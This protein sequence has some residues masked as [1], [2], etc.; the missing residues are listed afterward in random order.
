MANYEVGVNNAT[1]ESASLL[2]IAEASDSAFDA[3]TIFARLAIGDDITIR[4]RNNIAK[5]VRFDLAGAGSDLGT[6]WT[7]PVVQAAFVTPTFVDDDQVVLTF[8]YGGTPTPPMVALIYDSFSGLDGVSLPS[9]T[10]DIGAVWTKVEGGASECIIENGNCRAVTDVGAAYAY[11]REASTANVTLTCKMWIGA[12]SGG[13]HYTG[14][15]I[16]ATDANNYL[17]MTVSDLSA[18]NFLLEKHEAGVD[19]TLAT[20]TLTLTTNTWIDLEFS[21]NGSALSGTA[22]TTT[23]SATNSFNATATKCG[24]RL[25]CATSFFTYID[26]HKV[27]AFTTTAAGKPSPPEV[28]PQ[29]D[30][31]EH[32]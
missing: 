32:R 25:Y 16:R 27:E 10:P 22:G 3:S 8:T 24:F 15:I 7:F 9:H 23:I 29:G 1:V 6:Y 28:T 18:N 12:G 14:M 4:D 21:A 5:F 20:A 30:R 11:V 26:D 2:R 19:T 17:R 31:P 13:Q